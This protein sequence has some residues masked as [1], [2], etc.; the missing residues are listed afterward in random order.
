[1][2]RPGKQKENKTGRQMPNAI[3]MLAMS[4]LIW[5]KSPSTVQETPSKIL[6]FLSFHRCQTTQAAMEVKTR[7]SLL[8]YS[9]F[10]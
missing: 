10:G 8:S 5:T 4:V 3:D 1:M 7:F 6:L 2:A 9:F